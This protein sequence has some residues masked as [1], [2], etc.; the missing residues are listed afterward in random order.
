M[1]A[2]YQHALHP[3]NITG[4][5]SQLLFWENIL[6]LSASKMKSFSQSGQLIG[7]IEALHYIISP[8]LLTSHCKTIEKC[9]GW[10]SSLILSLLIPHTSVHLWFH[11]TRCVEFLIDFRVKTFKMF[12]FNISWESR[13]CLSHGSLLHVWSFT[14]SHSSTR[15]RPEKPSQRHTQLIKGRAVS[16]TH[17][18]TQKE[19]T[20]ACQRIGYT[21]GYTQA[22]AH[23]KKGRHTLW[24]TKHKHIRW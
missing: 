4:T 14:R 9:C 7:F 1:H 15:L 3:H 13:K 22:L 2:A 17:P 18:N 23:P 21:H 20:Q 19:N 10:A 6:Y 8:P 5:Q 16:D 12:L 24:P 11:G